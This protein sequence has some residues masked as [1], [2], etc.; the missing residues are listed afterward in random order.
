MHKLENTNSYLEARVKKLEDIMYERQ[1]T[2]VSLTGE[3]HHPGELKTEGILKSM[4]KQYTVN[5]L[6]FS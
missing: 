1:V 5:F 3:S 6:P 2:L 4:E